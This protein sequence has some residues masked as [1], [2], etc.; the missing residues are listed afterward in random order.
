MLININIILLVN[1]IWDRSETAYS[2]TVKAL[3]LN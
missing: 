1:Y 2:V 3:Q